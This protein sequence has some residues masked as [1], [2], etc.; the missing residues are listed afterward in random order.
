MCTTRYKTI[1]V[2]PQRGFGDLVLTL[3]VLHALR[4]L[5]PDARLVVGCCRRQFQLA[6]L[7]VGTVI[8]QVVD[9]GGKDWRSLLGLMWSIRAGYP[10]LVIDYQTRWYVPV[11]TRRCRTIGLNRRDVT[12]LP[13]LLPRERLP[14]PSPTHRVDKYVDLLRYL[15]H[16]HFPIR[17]DFP[18]DGVALQ[19]MIALMQRHDMWAENVVALVPQSS[20]PSKSWPVQTLR[21]TIDVLTFDMG[22]KV[23][24][25]GRQQGTE[26]YD[27]RNVLDLR[28][29][30]TL[31]EDCY[32]LRSQ[33]FKV[34]IGVDTGPMQLVGG[35]NSD[36]FGAY[37]S[38]TH[39]VYTV[40]LFGPTAPELHRPY[41]PTGKFNLVVSPDHGT[42][43]S[44]STG[45][46]LLSPSA[47]RS[48]ENIES[49][50]ILDAIQK[51]LD[52]SGV[53]S[54]GK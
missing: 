20:F 31:M 14:S 21:E 46:E 3:P 36:A 42:A 11:L 23:V 49:R 44:R 43:I 18:E 2:L 13:R 12:W 47:Y 17:F 6:D 9:V 50:A 40:S 22:L 51:Q 8:D 1:L 24:I 7:L 27:V 34:I 37:P 28:G 48:M 10:D 35:I 33:S 30:T 4:G 45:P 39:G 19:R 15:G 26:K 16:P 5:M 41:D 53:L 25:V 54:N 29:K 52:G 38:S 32:L